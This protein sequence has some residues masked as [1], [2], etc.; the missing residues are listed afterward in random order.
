MTSNAA[1]MLTDL[2]TPSAQK[3][4]QIFYDENSK[5]Q[6][7]PGFIPLD[8]SRSARA[9]WYEFWAIWNFLKTAELDEDCWYGFLSPKFREKTG[10]SSDF[11]SKALGGLEP[12]FEVA[13]FTPNTHELAYYQNPFEHGEAHHP[14]L[15]GIA[16]SF[17]GSRYPGLDLRE[18]VSCLRTSAF[19]N[20]VVAKPRYWRSW[21]ALADG[22]LA[23]A[24]A[25]APQSGSPWE[26]LV[27][28]QGRMVPIGVFIQERLPAVILGREPFKTFVPKHVLEFA[29]Y[30]LQ[31]RRFLFACDYLKESY[32]Y[33]GDPQLLTAFRQIR[34]NALGDTVK[35]IF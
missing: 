8:N 21:M 35:F 20:Y 10:L 29:Q 22:L 6:L 16:Q 17:F 18:H 19:C 11:V 33:T 13:L 14:S 31:Q 30:S 32:I 3:I 12:D 9:D 24:D 15:L 34:R 5:A 28:Y 25:S 23:Y 27:P 4:F 7:D 2:Q 26:S 1:G